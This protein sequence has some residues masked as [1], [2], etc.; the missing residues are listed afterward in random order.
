MPEALNPF[1]A[2]IP[3]DIGDHVDDSKE[4]KTL[5]NQ[6]NSYLSSDITD[7]CQRNLYAR[8]WKGHQRRIGIT[9]G[10]AS[11]KSSV[12]KYLKEIKALPIIDADIFSR[13][14]LSPGGKASEEVIKR[15]GNL[16]LKKSNFEQQEID[17]DA[18]AEI[19]FSNKNERSWLENLIHPIVKNKIEERL[20]ALHLEPTV[21]IV[22]PLLFECNMTS[23]CSEIWVV[24]CSLEEQLKRLI[25]RDCISNDQAKKRILAQI[26]LDTK[27]D[28]ADFVIENTKDLDQMES[29]VENFL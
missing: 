1:G 6:I 28:F 21:I 2:A 24:Y 9:G 18:L 8:R 5:A 3:P 15:Y 13:N 19:I 17:R 10:I 4:L 20:K 27:K 11:G 23:L 25:K 16:I 29:Q 7:Q 26:Q 12:S 14:V 22:I